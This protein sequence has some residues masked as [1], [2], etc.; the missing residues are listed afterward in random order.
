[1]ADASRPLNILA[2]GDSLT[3]GYRLPASASYPSLIQAWLQRDGVNARVANHGVNGDTCADA[4]RRLEPILQE[5]WDIAVVGL[6]LNDVWE[7]FS[8]ERLRRDLS[9]ILARLNEAGARL[10]LLE[11]RMPL[12]WP[13]A[14]M[15]AEGPQAFQALYPELA[16]AAG[17]ALHQDFMGPALDHG[18]VQEDGAHPTAAGMEAIAKSL[19]PAVTAMVDAY[20]DNQF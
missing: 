7:G 18:L 17:A 3:E 13:G 10:L 2:L 12:P 6:G 4:L 11:M 9:E 16:R 15:P 1:M 5:P 14:F 8:L 20:F 19:Y